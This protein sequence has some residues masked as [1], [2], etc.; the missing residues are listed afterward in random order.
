LADLD[1]R[2]EYT[3]VVSH[4]VDALAAIGPPAWMA[5]E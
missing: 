1:A 3:V 2:P 4:D 5:D